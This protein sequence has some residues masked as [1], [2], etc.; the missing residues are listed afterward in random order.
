MNGPL[1]GS[2][3]NRFKQYAPSQ[4]PRIVEIPI[5]NSRAVGVIASGRGIIN[6][7]GRGDPASAS[8]RPATRPA[9]EPARR[10]ARR[11]EA[12]RG[13]ARRT[14]TVNGH[15]LLIQRR[16]DGRTITPDVR[17]RASTGGL[18]RLEP[19]AVTVIDDAFATG[20]QGYASLTR[21]NY[22]RRP[23]PP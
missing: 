5:A 3:W 12:R 9:N 6:F 23:S 21:G 15:S 17:G 7:L 4:F 11:G 2:S 16:I 18:S 8:S 19:G 10:E 22:L 20:K 14:R 13:G 1:P